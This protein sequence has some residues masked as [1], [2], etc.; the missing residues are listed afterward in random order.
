MSFAA[1]ASRERNRA[2]PAIVIGL[3]VVGFAVRAAACPTRSEAGLPMIPMKIGDRSVRVEVVGTD[4]QRARGLMYRR[5]L[6][7]DRG[8]LFVYPE[9]SRLSFW[10]KNTF[11]PLTIAF[12][13]DDGTIVHL[14][15]MA[16]QT[17]TS[18]RS[19]KR[20][21]YALE[22]NRGWFAERDVS[23]GSH[24]TFELPSDLEVR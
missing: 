14:E 18:H 15:D 17:L 2:V 16:P 19:P 21:R 11:V 1:W 24:A 7:T 10:M 23:V 12:I 22:M 8:M 4:A 3:L 20:V 13:A 5:K 6:G 9:R